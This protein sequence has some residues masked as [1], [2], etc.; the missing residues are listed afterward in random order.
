MEREGSSQ[1]GEP[2]QRWTVHDIDL[3][4]QKYNLHNC[5]YFE[6]IQLKET[7]KKKINI[8]IF[9]ND[10]FFYIWNWSHWTPPKTPVPL[11]KVKC[12]SELI[13]Q[14][15]IINWHKMACNS[16]TQLIK[17]NILYVTHITTHKFCRMRF[18]DDD[19][20]PHWPHAIDNYFHALWLSSPLQ[21]PWLE[22]MSRLSRQSASAH[23]P[24]I[25]L[26]GDPSALYITLNF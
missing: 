7:I 24:T 26:L 15:F 2:I 4:K 13:T 19:K 18:S 11:S 9:H 21:S 14:Q 17:Y 1:P 22:V 8:N 23:C 10:I 16:K 12:I 3:I 5:C 20:C 6:Y 25:S